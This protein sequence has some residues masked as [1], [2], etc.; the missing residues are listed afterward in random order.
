HQLHVAFDLGTEISERPFNASLTRGRQGVQ[1]KPPSG[2]RFCTKGKG[3]QHVSATGDAAVANHIDPVANSVD[4]LGELVKWAPRRV[5]PTAAQVGRHDSSR[6]DV[7]STFCVR[8][9]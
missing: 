8:N 3:F 5:D 7:Y 2:T 1:I 6:A 9:A 4:D